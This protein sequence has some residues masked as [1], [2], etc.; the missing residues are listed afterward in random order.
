MP[1]PDWFVFIVIAS[2]ISAGCL[3]LHGIF[4]AAQIAMERAS[5]RKIRE[6]YAER[7]G[8][9]KKALRHMERPQRFLSTVSLIRILTIMVAAFNM[10]ASIIP[11]LARVFSDGAAPGGWSI[12]FAA[13]IVL[14]SLMSIWLF[15]GNLIPR[16]IAANHPEKSLVHT[17]WLVNIAAIVFRPFT[18]VL[19][20]ISNGIVSAMGKDPNLEDTPVTEEEVLRMIDESEEDGEITGVEADMIENI[21]DFN[22]KAVSEIMTHR[23]DV[24]ALKDTATLQ[25]VVNIAVKHGYSR[26]P[27]Y[28]GDIDCIIGVVYV[29]DLLKFIGRPLSRN[30]SVKALMRK[31]HLVP[32]S[33]ALNELFTEMTE[34]KIQ[35]A[36]LIDEYGGTE[37]IVTMEDILESIVGNIQD[38][39]DNEEE[40]IVRLSNILYTVSGGTSVDEVSELLDMELPEGDYDT[41]AGM[42]VEMLGNI[43]DANEYP[44]VTVENVDFQVL[45]FKDNRIEKILIEKHP[46]QT[47]EDEET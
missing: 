8:K 3:V 37:G 6:L 35:F 33:K 24:L 30:I 17:M 22:D 31:P 15:I 16:K 36:V 10:C 28:H 5:E 27:I 20:G 13:A 9:Q 44:T 38:E 2:A 1:D 40:D 43:P 7:H 23:M 34:R 47:D 46:V 26:I 14:A 12:T 11:P 4:S 18:F 29:K 45:E 19:G 41:I 21:F 42:V 32:E 25:D 39:Y